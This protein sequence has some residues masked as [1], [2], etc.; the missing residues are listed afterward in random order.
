ML[1]VFHFLSFTCHREDIKRATGDQALD[2]MAL[3][4]RRTEQEEQWAREREA[5][6]QQQATN[7]LPSGALYPVLSHSV[8]SAVSLI[9][10]EKDNIKVA[11]LLLL[12]PPLCSHTGKL[13]LPG[14]KSDT[15]WVNFESLQVESKGGGRGGRTDLQTK[16]ISRDVSLCHSG[17]GELSRFH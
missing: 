12:P 5:E 10:S 6:E 14:D 15:H 2:S 8:I 13:G 17:M 3:Q 7:E 9:F 1:V 16:H 4:E 11:Y